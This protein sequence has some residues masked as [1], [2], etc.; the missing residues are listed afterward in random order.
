[1][2]FRFWRRF[3]DEQEELSKFTGGDIY[4]YQVDEC[5]KKILR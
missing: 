2:K 1:M 4:D 5:D 3:P